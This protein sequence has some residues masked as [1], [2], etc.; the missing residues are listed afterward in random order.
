MASAIQDTIKALVE[1]ESELGQA[2]SDATETARM[3]VKNADEWTETAK[4]SALAKAQ[5]IASATLDEARSA[6]ENDAES[7]RKK[8]ATSLRSFESLI[9][10]RKTRAVKLV[11]SQLLGEN[12]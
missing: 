1:F 2:K 10:G 9:Q 8:G 7:I 3:L 4:A 12:P 5:K 6:A 11:V